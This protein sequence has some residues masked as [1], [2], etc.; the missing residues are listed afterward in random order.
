M[1]RLHADV[2]GSDRHASAGN[3]SVL[4]VSPVAC[5]TPPLQF[6]GFDQLCELVADAPLQ[7]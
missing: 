4:I 6:A 2:A 7:T 3:A 5:A 1:L